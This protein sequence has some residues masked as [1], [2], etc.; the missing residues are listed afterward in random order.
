MPNRDKAIN[1]NLFGSNIM[2]GLG[3][4]GKIKTVCCRFQWR[5]NIEGVKKKNIT[6]IGLV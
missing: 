1:F 3:V 6:K 4:P 5:K 2:G